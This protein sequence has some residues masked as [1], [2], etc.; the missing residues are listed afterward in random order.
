MK[1]RYRSF[2]CNH[3][4]KPA[5]RRGAKAWQGGF[6]VY[7]PTRPTEASAGLRDAISPRK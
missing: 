1:Y 7:T 6:K 2:N 3:S 4:V 5:R